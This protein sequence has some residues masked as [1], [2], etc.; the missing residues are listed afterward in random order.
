MQISPEYPSKARIAAGKKVINL[1][2]DCINSEKSF[3]IESTLSGSF[4]SKHIDI[5]KANQYKV[6]IIYI[7][8]GSKDLCVERIKSRVMQGGHHVPTQDVY[9]RFNRGLVKFWNEYRMK[10]DFYSI[11]F[12]NEFYDFK[13]ISQGQKDRL[14]VFIQPLFEEFMKIVE[15]SNHE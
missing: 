6:I 14:E 10:V 8:L 4:L 13:Q 7:F 5:L 15:E 2:T 3:V 12:N 9:R 1:I 11:Y